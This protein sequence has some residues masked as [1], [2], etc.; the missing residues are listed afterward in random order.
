[1]LFP[2]QRW[3]E[4][5][6]ALQTEQSTFPEVKIEVQE[7]QARHGSGWK[8]VIS[9]IIDI[10]RLDKFTCTYIQIH[11]VD[12]EREIER[13]RGREGERERGGEGEG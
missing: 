8:D 10:Y 11:T 2:A 1:M 5:D 6:P 12:A 4:L 13:E 9:N 7:P 3:S